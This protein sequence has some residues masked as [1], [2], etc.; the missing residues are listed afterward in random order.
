MKS[1]LKSS[2]LLI[3]F[4]FSTVISLRAQQAGSYGK[5]V[6]TLIGSYPLTDPKIL[7]YEL[8]KDWRSWAGLTFPGSSMPNAMVQLSPMT[9]Y[10]S[11]AGYEYEDDIIY[12]FTHTNKGHWNLCNIPLMP[13]SE[14]GI[15][16]AKAAIAA[17]NNSIEGQGRNP[18]DFGSKFSHARE[19]SSPGFYQVYLDNYKVKVS[20]TST[21]RCGFHRYEF[22]SPSGRQIIFDL[23]RANNRI[24]EWEISQSG[25]NELQGSQ[26]TGE[27]IYFYALLNTEIK[28]LEKTDEGKAGGYA[29]IKLADG[30][31][32]PV[33]VKIGISFVSAQNAK[34]NLEK[35]IGTKSFEQIH[36]EATQTWEQVLSKIQLK[37]GTPKQKELLYSC[38]YRS[39]LWPALRS[40]VNGEYTDIR[41]KPA[42]S[43]DFNY[44]TEPSLWDT[45]RN[46]DVLLG[47]ISPKV[48]LD[49]IKSMKDVGD[50]TGFIP[51]FFHG[52]HG[53]SS[54]AGAYLRGI[55]D[56]DIKGT[57]AILLRNANVSPGARPHLEEYIKKGYISDPDI[58]HPEVET[59]A[60]AGVS[61]TLE[62]SY[63]DYS[64]AQLA[65]KLGDTANYRILM[66]RSG[67]YKNMFDPG[68]RFMRGRLENGDWIK[69]FDPQQP[70]YEYMYREANAWQVS[71][72]AP[73]DMKGLIKLYGGPAG[74]ES[75]L[76]SLFT[77]PW[78]PKH[79]A[80]NVETF[81]GQYCHGNQPDHEAP[82]AYTFI[83]K[84]EKTQKI[85]DNILN[86]LYGIGDKG[87][88]LA[89]MD[90]AGEMSAWYVMS[91]LGLYTFSATDPEYL[92]TAPLFDEVK[93][94]TSTG[95]TL[96]I[97]KPGKGR[98][99]T[100]I[101]VNGKINTG[102]FV[103]HDLFL[104]GGDIAITTK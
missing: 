101:R 93:W 50:K 13:V 80:R 22:A 29:R 83:G 96:T 39:L 78:N 17:S 20:L 91:A 71:F 16:E 23:G 2:L 10:G 90:D 27:H 60:S 97:T 55:N 56:F 19:Q 76:D 102:Y 61:K 54:I 81:I 69:P 98:G 30:T 6:N 42:K 25:K 94:K 44:Y 4:T 31:K 51:T 53:A 84:P 87:L 1:I 68:T 24:A 67:N 92:V 38:L 59:K 63:D 75:K 21:L 64:L 36:N 62:Y 52:D 99:I 66:A 32:G 82:F 34:E 45:Y 74:F 14:A 79:I 65:K 41:M 72:F 57:Y 46:K 100:A 8:P 103:S 26:K 95:K 49:V 28:S 70:Y 15:S 12:G 47:L 77:L 85:V 11:G 18:R 7:G 3:T 73:H 37:G 33:E 104:H 35:E 86:N 89:G 58:A 9:E 40:D 5:Y 88:A 43:A 48:A